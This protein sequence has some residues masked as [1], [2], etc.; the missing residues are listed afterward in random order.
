MECN[1]IDN[2]LIDFNK[3]NESINK[4]NEET[5]G[6][7]NDFLTTCV[8]KGGASR[9]TKLNKYFFI[10][11]RCLIF[12]VFTEHV[13]KELIIGLSPLLIRQLSIGFIKL[14][15]ILLIN[16]CLVQIP[17]IN[18]MCPV[19]KDLFIEFLN[20]LE[21]ILIKL[22][23]ILNYGIN[24]LIQLSSIRDIYNDSKI[25]YYLL[26][27]P[28]FIDDIEY[29]VGTVFIVN[30]NNYPVD[31]VQQIN[32]AIN[33][34]EQKITTFLGNATQ[35]A[36]DIKYIPRGIQKMTFLTRRHI[37]AEDVFITSKGQEIY[38]HPVYTRFYINI[39]YLTVDYISEDEAKNELTKYLK[40]R[41]ESGKI[42]HLLELKYNIPE[43]SM[44]SIAAS[45]GES[46]K[47]SLIE[48]NTKS[49]STVE[50]GGAKSIFRKATRKGRKK[51]RR[52]GT[53]KGRKKST[54]KIVM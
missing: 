21:I 40:D 11:L 14:L 7:F 45:L 41:E 5:K 8:T 4:Y 6:E 29:P 30:K 28:E 13:L 39:G 10:I 33:S 32:S 25:F 48:S 50:K 38:L 20:N 19:Y 51:T 27:N 35:D 23:P 37:F 16:G 52:K 1:K 31:F 49:S 24:K 2:G 42:L 34:D 12:S 43:S 18:D 46:Y 26:N 17:I 9:D 3:F 15:K 53:R 36:S 47:T 54:A 22:G 44:R